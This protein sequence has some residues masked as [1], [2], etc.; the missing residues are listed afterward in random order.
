MPATWLVDQILHTAP[1]PYASAAAVADSVMREVAGSRRQGHAVPMSLERRKAVGGAE[2]TDVETAGVAQAAASRANAGAAATATATV[3]AISAAEPEE[4]RAGDAVTGARLL[5]LQAEV[6]RLQGLLDGTRAELRLRRRW[7][8]GLLG[9]CMGDVVEVEVE[10]TRAEADGTAGLLPAG[11]PNSG[12]G[13]SCRTC[14][15]VKDAGPGSR[16]Q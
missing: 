1:P 7:C 9:C 10:A 8:G 6:K 5:E 16:L 3:S 11:S 13:G 15:C 12:G 4:V 2:T 14:G